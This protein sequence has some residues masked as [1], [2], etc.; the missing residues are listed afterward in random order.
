MMVNVPRWGNWGLGGEWHHSSAMEGRNLGTHPILFLLG[1]DLH[2]FALSRECS[3][4][5]PTLELLMASPGE[6]RESPTL[7]VFGRRHK[8][9][10]AKAEPGLVP[11]GHTSAWSCWKRSWQDAYQLRKRLS[12]HWARKA[13]LQHCAFGGCVL[14][15]HQVKV[16]QPSLPLVQPFL[17]LGEASVSP[18]L[19]KPSAK[20]SS[21]KQNI[22]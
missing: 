17:S 7:Q 15:I 20:Q 5:T 2:L 4:L 1:C 22:Q 19:T 16:I 13:A 12:S 18:L 14:Q 21:V 3:P 10:A 11:A 6:W 9:T 8:V